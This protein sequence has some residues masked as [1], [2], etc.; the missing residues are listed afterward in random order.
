M[1]KILGLDLGTNSIGWAVVCE[2]HTEDMTCL[3]GIDGAGSRIIPM[4]ADQL[5]DFEKGNSISQTKERTGYRGTRRLRERF[6]LRRERLHR[7]LG[8]MGFLP[9]HYAAYIDEFGKF[10]KGTEPKIEWRKME[11]GKYEFIFQSSFNEMLDNFRALH[12]ESCDRKI[13]SDWTL[14]YLRKKAL[15]QKISKEEL[16]WILLN[17]NQKRG[18]YQL[19]GEEDVVDASKKEEYMKL[20]VIDVIDSGE[21]KGKAT[22]YNVKLDNG[23]IYRRASEQPLDWIGKEKEFIITTKLEKDGSVKKDKDGLPQVS[24]RSPKDDDWNLVKKRTESDIEGSC[25][26]VGEYIY[27]NILSNP[28]LKIIGKLVR[29]IERKYYRAELKEIIRKQSEFH[30]ELS[31][32]TLY[33]KCLNVLYPNNEAYRNSI[34][35]KDFIYLLAEDLIF[36]QRPLKSKKHLISNCPYETRTYLDKESGELKTD[37][38][39]CIAKSHPLFQEFRLWQFIN[40][41]RIYSADGSNRD[42]TDLYLREG[43]DWERLFEFLKDKKEIDQP[44]FI[45]K[46][47]GLKKVGDKFPVR[48][49]YVED[50]KYPCNKTRHEICAKLSKEESGK[51]TDDLL[52][53]IWHLLYSVKTKEE[54]DAVFS[55]SK[56]GTEGIYDELLKHFSKESIERIKSIRLEEEDYGSYSE[57]AIKKL[58]SLMRLGKYWAP[59]LIDSKASDRIAKILSGEFDPGIKDNIRQRAAGFTCIN[60]F[61][62][63]PVWFACYVVYGRHS[64]GKEARKWHCPKDIDFFLAGFK[65]HSM[66]NPIVEQV[67]TETLRTVRDIWIKT[68]RIDEIHIELGRELKSTKEQRERITHRNI[69]NE[70][71]NQRIRTLLTEFFNSDFNIHG[72]RIEGVRPHSPS[73]QDTLKIYEETVLQN[74]RERN[75][76]INN[77]INKLN[78]TDSAKRPTKAEILKYALWLDQK[79]CSPYTGQPIPLAKLFTHEYEIEHIIPQ[80]RYFDDSFQNK[81]ICEAEVNKLKDRLLGKEFINKHHG[82]I[83][84]C[85]GG[86]TVTIQSIE[87]Y[88]EFVKKHYSG[89]RTKLRNLLLEDIPDG[90]IERQMNDTRYISRYIMGLL[91]NIVRE[92]I[93]PGVFE[94]EATSKNLIACNGSITTRL[95]KDWGLNDVWNSIILP[96]FIRLNEICKTDR[97]T[98]KNSEG[99]TIPDMPDEL[100]RGFS[101]KR[102]DHRHHAMDAIVIAC[103][104]RSH[105]HLLNNEAAKSSNKAIRHQLSHKLRRYEKIVINGEERQV[106]KEFL[107]PWETFTQ[108]VHKILKEII[109]SFK[110]N[111]RVINKASNKYI[112]YY[113]ENGNLRL[114]KSGLPVKGMTTQK[115]NANWWAIRKPLHKDTVFAKVHLRKVKEVRL[116]LALSC[117]DTIVDKELK[118]EIKR[119]LSMGYD[120]KRIKKFFTDGENK[121][122]WAEFNPNKIK[123]YYFTEDTFA[124]RKVLDDSFDEKKIKTSVTDSG[125]QKILLKHLEEN[126]GDPKVAFSPDGIERMNSN[127]NSL[128]EGKRHQP[129]Y[130]VRIYEAASKFAVGTCGNKADKFVEAAKGTNLY[131]GVY[132]DE[133]GVRTFETVALNEVIER[134]KQGLSPVPET[135]GNNAKLLFCLSPNDLIYVPSEEELVKGEIYVN[136]DRIYKMVSSSGPQCFFIKGTVATCIVNKLEFSPLNKMERAISGEMIKEICIPIK[137]DRLGNIIYIG[138]E[139]LP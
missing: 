125:I 57:K 87:S 70:N 14:Y 105:I 132:A 117:V 39:K 26:T 7:T 3:T 95:K 86:R 16:A 48:W 138:T 123:V 59:N 10:N 93:A 78:S 12:P 106:A 41:L 40:N 103:A 118:K 119:L 44:T 56:I 72:K 9:E 22:W 121:D 35:G 130:K 81:V 42:I 122:I 137:V 64:E 53:K 135:N 77:I 85:T 124:T 50:K 73:Q 28:D 24:I 4:S 46:F 84:R 6:L 120:E 96:R 108:D 107:K 52:A 23:L 79:Y 99:H 104:T 112:S 91:S 83:V 54:I 128:N 65:Q 5:G 113:D 111:L 37:P 68:G 38:I 98:S 1:K 15:T 101:K 11:N 102:I 2:E 115:T 32:K 17:F 71:T 100:L 131:F 30:P 110:Q 58:L 74:D 43:R 51:L 116:S 63:L 76:E 88:E 90:F 109:V 94:E 60:D 80:S 62:G 89:N 29:T 66:R 134:L 139:Y 126:K 49:N 61:Q 82:E 34:L 8:I 55:D 114:D 13:P 69:E 36:Y 33:E 92:E 127:L 19:R 25:K 27:D 136:G 45:S 129:I 20:T 21:K 67:V 18:Y 31:D 97:F 75:D 47:L 133:N